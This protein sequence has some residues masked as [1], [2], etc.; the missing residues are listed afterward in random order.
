MIKQAYKERII[1]LIENCEDLSI[2]D[3]VFQTLKKLI[4]NAKEILTQ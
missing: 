4:P 2:L 1:K 3:L